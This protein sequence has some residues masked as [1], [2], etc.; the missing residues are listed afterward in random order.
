MKAPVVCA[1]LAVTSRSIRINGIL[2]VLDYIASGG[3]FPVQSDIAAT[4]VKACLISSADS[5]LSCVV[6]E[7]NQSD[8]T[9]ELSKYKFNKNSPQV[10]QKM[11]MAK[12][13]GN[14]QIFQ[15]GGVGGKP[16]GGS[17]R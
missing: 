10:K 2:H 14:T 8:P 5:G 4:L 1:E 9:A 7:Y 12:T 13:R 11:T 3:F 17:P 6:M 15:G 16:E